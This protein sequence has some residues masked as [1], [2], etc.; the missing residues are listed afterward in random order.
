MPWDRA[1]GQHTSFL[2]AAPLHMACPRPVTES[3]D[4]LLQ[5]VQLP[6][7]SRST[8]LQ[9][10]HHPCAKAGQLPPLA[11]TSSLILVPSSLQQ[12]SCPRNDSGNSNDPCGANIKQEK[13][14]AGNRPVL[15]EGVG[16]RDG[17][18]CTNPVLVQRV[19]QSLAPTPSPGS[20]INGGGS[21][22]GHWHPWAIC[23]L[24]AYE[25][26]GEKSV[27]RNHQGRSSEVGSADK[28]GHW[29][30]S[31]SAPWGRGHSL[32]SNTVITS[33]LSVLDFTPSNPLPSVFPHRGFK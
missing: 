30:H 25:A 16:R 17:K 8:G 2:P 6:E 4:L 10:P 31:A 21:S 19:N 26:F 3:M 12:V 11:S 29:S 1:E 18:V 15:T 20:A 32:L 22:Y 24:I 23:S 9:P 13:I 28:H 27:R 5:C 7:A 14:N 33:R